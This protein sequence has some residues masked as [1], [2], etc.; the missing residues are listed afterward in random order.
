MMHHSHIGSWSWSCSAI[1]G[2]RFFIVI[3]LTR[4]DLDSAIIL[5]EKMIADF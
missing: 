2:I 5:I 3:I 4:E 1:A